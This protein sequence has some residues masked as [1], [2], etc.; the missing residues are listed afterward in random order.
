MANGTGGTGGTGGTDWASKLAYAKAED[1]IVNMGKGGGGKPRHASTGRDYIP[2]VVKQTI[3][4]GPLRRDY[5][6]VA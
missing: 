2:D 5:D 3:E 6:Q 4:T 1:Y